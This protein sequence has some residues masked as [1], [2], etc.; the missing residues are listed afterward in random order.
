MSVK[1]SRIPLREIKAQEFAEFLV[2]KSVGHECPI[3]KGQYGMNVRDDPDLVALAGYPILAAAKD[4]TAEI[5]HGQTMV[6]ATISC[7]NCGYMRTFVT[8]T[9]LEWLA[10]KNHE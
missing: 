8:D 9:I 7:G 5:V 1:K 2:A 4:G 6:V 10:T 3:C